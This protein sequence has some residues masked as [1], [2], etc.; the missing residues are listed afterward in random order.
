[1]KQD[2]DL[3]WSLQIE[4]YRAHDRTGW[5]LNP[6]VLMS[7]GR[8]LMWSQPCTENCEDGVSSR[9]SYPASQRAQAEGSAAMRNQMR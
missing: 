9:E 7:M 4:L 6:T 5:A 2:S 3:L 1:M 8:D